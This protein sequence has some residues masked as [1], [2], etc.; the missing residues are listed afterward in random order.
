LPFTGL[1]DPCAVAV[2]TA[3]AVYVA[4]RKV[5]A[6]QFDTTALPRRTCA[7][8]THAA[9]DAGRHHHSGAALEG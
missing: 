1:N 5:P 6:N 7:R 2:G 9:E 4:D 3:G 8:R